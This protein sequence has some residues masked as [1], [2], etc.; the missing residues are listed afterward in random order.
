MDYTLSR[1]VLHSLKRMVTYSKQ[2]LHGPLL[3]LNNFSS[4]EQHVQLMATMLQNMFP[5]LN[6]HKVR[7][8]A[9]PAGVGSRR[10]GDPSSGRTGHVS[11]FR[12]HYR[13]PVTKCCFALR[14]SVSGTDYLENSDP[15]YDQKENFKNRKE[16][17][18]VC[19]LFIYHYHLQRHAPLTCE[20][21]EGD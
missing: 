10:L 21:R 1:D 13:P 14:F 11:L 9:R 3:I 5:V 7:P 20:F 6:I 4:G 8:A 16:G 2:F 15:V 17:W 12:Y 19:L 18:I